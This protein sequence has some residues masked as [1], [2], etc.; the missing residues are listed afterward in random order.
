MPINGIARP[1]PPQQLQQWLRARRWDNADLAALLGVS[2][3]HVRRLLSGQHPVSQAQRMLLRL[4]AE[5]ERAMR[6]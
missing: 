4:H 2:E 6:R 3:R 1:M 5:Q